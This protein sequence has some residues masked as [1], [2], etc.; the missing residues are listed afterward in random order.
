MISFSLPI[1]TSFLGDLD[2]GANAR[3]GCNLHAMETKWESRG[4][5]SSDKLHEQQDCCPAVA[6]ATQGL[7]NCVKLANCDVAYE[8]ARQLLCDRGKE[9][10][11]S[12]KG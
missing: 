10:P 1:T 3:A 12:E 2:T 8:V 5:R 6:V 7:R 4:I 9:V 11:E